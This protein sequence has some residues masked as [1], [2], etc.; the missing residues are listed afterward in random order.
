[1]PGAFWMC[2][3]GSAVGLQIVRVFM[4][5]VVYV[6]GPRPGVTSL[7]MGGLAIAVF[8]TAWLA[9]PAQRLLGPRL[10]AGTALAM[11]G[12]RLVLQIVP[13]AVALPLAAAG[14]AVTLWF[15][16]A[17]FWRTRTEGA[18]A[19]AQA[20]LALAAG[21]AL[22]AAI[23]GAFGTW[24]VVWQRRPAALVT[25]VALA[26][27]LA[28]LAARG[29]DART[30]APAHGSRV[31]DRGSL[32][33]APAGGGWAL[34]ALGPLLFLHLLLFQ[35]TARLAAGTG[36]G[37]P[38]AL[39]W[40]LASDLLAVAVGAWL[41]GPRVGLAAAVLLVPAAA[42]AHGAGTAAAVAV[43]VGTVASVVLM[44]AAIG[45]PAARTGS[46]AARTAGWGLAM[47]GLAVPTVVYYLTYDIRTP[48]ENAVIPP[49]LAA[50]AAVLAGRQ[51][52]ALAALPELQ[53]VPARTLRVLL[54][55][56]VLLWAVQRPPEEVV[57]AGWP[58]RVMS[59]NLHQGYG[60]AGAQDLEAL[61]RA[62]E[63]EGAE[64]VALQEVS[65]GWV[66]NGSTD[67]LA[68]LARRLRMAA[69]WAPAADVAWGNAVLSRRPILTSTVVPLPRGLAAMRRSVLEVQVEIGGRD[70]LLVLATHFHHV[71]AEGEIRR[72][73]AAA[74]VRLWNQ[75][76]RAAVLGDLNA[77]PDA[78]EIAML[79]GAGLRDAFEAAGAGDGHTY[80]ASRP[81]RRID[82]VWISP[83]LSAEAF[84]TAGGQASDHL[85]VAVTLRRENR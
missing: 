79:R 29:R 42:L 39:F 18:D 74:L 47:L 37:L 1:M 43:T 16:A 67:L 58:V 77:V 3:I 30:T 66:I 19:G 73:Q 17:L 56:P 54:L 4:P 53:A 50:L 65:R 34:A 71:E 80:P 62:I 76:D 51:A 12:V 35:N 78:P 27:L 40:I 48:V 11:A 46:G 38:A 70:R 49:T 6:Y 2:T 25:G 28:A 64:V 59:Y 68:W 52:L 41:R 83:D 21:L 61:A 33:A 63:A 55:V 36:W 75:R 15:W 69:A 13:A 82:Y 26:A 14:V 32:P 44:V 7:H 22:D 8:L 84:R 72:Q 23:A 24:D 45:A 60:M 10:L 9:G 81:A 31:Q 85:G 20:A 5:L 57:G